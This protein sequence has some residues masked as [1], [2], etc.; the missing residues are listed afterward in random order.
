MA[1]ETTAKKKVRKP[2]STKQ[3]AADA[4]ASG[5]HRAKLQ[6]A[7]IP[8]AAQIDRALATF[9]LRSLAADAARRGD[10]AR[11]DVLVAKAIEGAGWPADGPVAKTVTA[12]AARL[13]T[14]AAPSEPPIVE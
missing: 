2:R 14:T 10:P 1:D 11:M 6:A 9:F 4:G 5:R 3:K 8:N 13:A 7:G 12:R